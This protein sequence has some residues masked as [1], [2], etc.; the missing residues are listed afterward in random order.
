M[1]IQDP[2][3]YYNEDDFID[4]GNIVR[5]LKNGL[6]R[7]WYIIV[8]VMILFGSLAFVYQ[9]MS[10]VPSYSSSA[11]VIISTNYGLT[12]GSSILSDKIMTLVVGNVPNIMNNGSL[13]K[14][15]AADLGKGAVPG[16]ITTEEIADTNMFIITC[17]ATSGQ[18]SYDI[19]QSVIKMFPVAAE[20]MIGAATI[21][22]IDD[23]GVPENPATEFSFM[24]M[25]LIGAVG[26]FVLSCIAIVMISLLRT[27]IRKEKD[28]IRVLNIEC[29]GGIP[30]VVFKRRAK[31]EKRSILVT[32][33]GV[34]YDFCEAFNS[35]CTRIE[36]DQK[37][38]DAKVYI[39]SST[40][41]E[42]G[43]STFAL[44]LAYT[45][46]DIGKKVILLDMDLHNPSIL[47]I[48][49]K[50]DTGKGLMDLL[51]GREKFE[52]V[53]ISLDERSISVLPGID[54]ASC[55]SVNS[56]LNSLN[57]K[58]LIDKARE[59]ADIILIDAASVGLFSDVTEIAKY[60]DGAIYVIAQD[61]VPSLRVKESVEFLAEC[62]TR[63]VGG[64]LNKAVAGYNNYVGS[65]GEEIGE[66]NAQK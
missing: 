27:T 30:K 24:T 7:F 57:M 4:F 12:Y 14:L 52:D 21:T 51:E 64:I 16:T 2:S 17:T 58:P 25:V 35:L 3:L 32:E 54:P 55:A 48:L 29:L 34:G 45:F 38:N 44:N 33:R 46:A 61:F 62:G 6:I 47:K 65:Y 19:L 41:Q 42:E 8:I 13:N 60:A 49:G 43:K 5:D 31:N 56:I 23:S 11:T 26:A 9:K 63:I 59:S 22:V 39:I 40:V 10:Y 15:V 18:T 28:F 53:V 20:Q 1:E 37:E 36:R 66:K 50:E